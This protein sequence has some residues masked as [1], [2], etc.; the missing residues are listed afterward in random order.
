[1]KKKE[2][3]ALEKEV[4]R[5]RELM[6]AE[7]PSSDKYIKLSRQY[8]DLLQELIDICDKKDTQRVSLIKEI[9]ALTISFI[10]TV[11]I[12][13]VLNSTMFYDSLEFSKTDILPPMAKNFVTGMLRRIK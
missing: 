1:M 7:D 9:G 10:G 5:V 8:K 4:N 11:G 6:V 12:G 2:I 13:I 3:E